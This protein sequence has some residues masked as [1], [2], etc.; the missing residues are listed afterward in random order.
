MGLAPSLGTTSTSCSREGLVM[1][2]EHE[3]ILRRKLVFIVG[4]LQ[5]LGDGP[6]D[7]DVVLVVADV[8]SSVGQWIRGHHDV[9]D[10]TSIASFAFVGADAR[11]LLTDVPSRPGLVV[12][13]V[14]AHNV[15]LPFRFISCPPSSE[16]QP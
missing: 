16:Q 13:V 11:R 4:L 2:I 10:A 9:N 3:R 8:R 5:I 7:D 1:S 6:R 15:G 14:D 12:I